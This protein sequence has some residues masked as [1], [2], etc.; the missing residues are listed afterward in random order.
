[1]GWQP[2]GLTYYDG[3]DTLQIT[4]EGPTITGFQVNE[5]E[6]V[7]V[8]NKDLDTLIRFLIERQ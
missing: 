3:A 8:E 2:R 4:D 7:L 5:S 6:V 1:M